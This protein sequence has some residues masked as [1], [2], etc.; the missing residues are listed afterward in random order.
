MN[1]FGHVQRTDCG[2][3]GRKMLRL[4]FQGGLE[5]EQSGDSMDVVGGDMKLVCERGRSNEE[6]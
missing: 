2:Y 5:E 4:E 6:K 1:W 3:I